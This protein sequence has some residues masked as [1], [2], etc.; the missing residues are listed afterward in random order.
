MSYHIAR[1]GTGDIGQEERVGHPV[2]AL[3]SFSKKPLSSALMGLGDAVADF[4]PR[5][6]Q[7]LQQL[8]L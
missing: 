8:A 1:S 7:F 3:R 4:A 5:V 6:R 2:K